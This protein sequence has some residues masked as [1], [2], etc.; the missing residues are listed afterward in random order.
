[1]KNTASNSNLL[2]PSAKLSDY[3]LGSYNSQT[4]MAKQK[5]KIPKK[6]LQT[7]KKN[8]SMHEL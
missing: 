1:M 3:D 4:S 2:I 5:Y 6:T 8:T 7:M